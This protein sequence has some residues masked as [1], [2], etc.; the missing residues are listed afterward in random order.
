MLL[1]KLQ[2]LFEL[3]SCRALNAH[4][5]LLLFDTDSGSL[6]CESAFEHMDAAYSGLEIKAF[7][8]GCHMIK[9]VGRI[10][11]HETKQSCLH[12]M[13]HVNVNIWRIEH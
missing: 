11:L 7:L 13:C 1:D 10:C 6:L 9:Y 3:Y 4:T 8:H 2:E 5:Q 12:E